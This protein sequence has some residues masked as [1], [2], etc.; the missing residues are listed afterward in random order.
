MKKCVLYISPNERIDY[1]HNI[2]KKSEVQYVTY[3]SEDKNAMSFNKGAS[4]AYNRNYLSEHI[5]KEF[6]YY[7]FMDYD[8]VFDIKQEEVEEKIDK[9]LEEYYPAIMTL[10]NTNTEKRIP[11][12]ISNNTQTN[13]H[14][15]IIHHSLLD[16]FF[17]MFD[18]F[19]GFHD[20][21]LFFNTLALPFRRNTIHVHDLPCKGTVSAPYPQ[22]VSVNIDEQSKVNLWNWLKP[23]FGK[24]MTYSTH[25]ELKKRELRHCSKV[26]HAKNNS[27][28]CYKYDPEYV[29]I[30]HEIFNYRRVGTL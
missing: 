3:L 10:L 23:S 25:H 26:G 21:S 24:K 2:F 19:G 11:G 14:L 16:Y 29:D 17:P 1:I 18:R 28:V 12:L 22:N 6:D 9:L 8:V 7:V 20:C 27:D 4:W 30:T 13:N 15:K 5:Q